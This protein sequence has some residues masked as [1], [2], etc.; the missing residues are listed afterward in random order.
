LANNIGRSG[1]AEGGNGVLVLYKAAVRIA[2]CGRESESKK[3]GYIGQYI[4]SCRV[5]EK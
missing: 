5:K 1:T 4:I 2:E 3:G